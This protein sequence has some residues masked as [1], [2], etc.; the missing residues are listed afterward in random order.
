MRRPIPGTAP[1]RLGILLFMTAAVLALTASPAAASTEPVARAGGFLSHITTV[2]TGFK[3]RTW[4]DLD[5]DATNAYILF[6]R[7][8]SDPRVGV[9]NAD[10]GKKIA[11]KIMSCRD[12]EDYF[13]FGDLPAGRYYFQIMDKHSP[14]AFSVTSVLVRYQSGDI[15]A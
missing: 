8:T 3:S 15:S 5:D 12:T 14:T 13:Y 7:C 9:F 1:R 10:T 4:T 6:I 2:A 11:D